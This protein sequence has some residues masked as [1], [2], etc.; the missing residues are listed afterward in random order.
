MSDIYGPHDMIHVKEI[1]LQ[2]V[3]FKILSIMRYIS[4]N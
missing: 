4:E 1:Q 3:L 2:I